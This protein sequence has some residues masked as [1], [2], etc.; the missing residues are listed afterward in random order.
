MVIYWFKYPAQELQPELKAQQATGRPRQMSVHFN[1]LTLINL[2]CVSCTEIVS[3]T[4][5]W[6]SVGMILSSVLGLDMRVTA[7]LFPISVGKDSLH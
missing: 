7:P 5:D 1:L 4:I 2:A 3:N 6:C